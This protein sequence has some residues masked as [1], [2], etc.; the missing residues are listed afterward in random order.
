[1]DFKEWI[2]LKY[3]QWRGDSRKTVTAF[4]AWLN[5]KQSLMTHWMNGKMI[6]RDPINIAKLARRYGREVYDILGFYLP[7]DRTGIS[8]RLNAGTL[9]KEQ[10]HEILLAADKYVAE[11]QDEALKKS[12]FE[13]YM[14]DHGIEVLGVDQD[15]PLLRSDDPD[16][17]EIIGI[18]RQLSVEERLEFM[19]WG[20]EKL[21][22]RLTEKSHGREK[23]SQNPA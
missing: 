15:L 16:L 8:Y 7:P 17:D 11:I 12:E 4:A 3:A 22:G 2:N 21:I 14:L 18:Y 6:A 9:S 19:E 20:K 1:M 13:K 5:I 23:H 10:I